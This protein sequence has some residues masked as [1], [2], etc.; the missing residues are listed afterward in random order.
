MEYVRSSAA[1]A[2]GKIGEKGLPILREALN[3]PIL[4]QREKSDI[5]DLIGR[6]ENQ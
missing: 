1:Y 5:E 4:T 6:L 3:H 2:A